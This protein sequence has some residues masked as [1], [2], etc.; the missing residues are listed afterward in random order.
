MEFLS[1]GPVFTV[2]LQGPGAVEIARKIIGHT[3]PAEASPG[4]VRGDFGL[5]SA[6]LSNVQKRTTQNLIHASGSKEEAEFERKLWFREKEI[7]P[8]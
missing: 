3:F 2:L 5:D 1:S 7:Y 6:H 4:T 8:Y